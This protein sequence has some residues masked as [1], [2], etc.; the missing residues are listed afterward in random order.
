MPEIKK[1]FT[2]GKMNKDL[3]ERLVPNG[4][5]RDAMNIQVS[6]SEDS[7][8]GTVQ[9]ILGN[10]LV[11]TLS[12]LSPNSKCV[13]SISDEKDNALYWFVTNVPGWYVP[14]ATVIN[15]AF[16]SGST[17]GVQQSYKDIIL[18]FKNGFV[19]P[20]FVALRKDVAYTI[21][22]S[23]GIISWNSAAS[24][25]TLPPSLSVTDLEVGMVLYGDSST[26]GQSFAGM[27]ISGIDASTNTVTISGDI[28]WIDLSASSPAGYH[29]TKLF[30]SVLSGSKQATIL[31][32]KIGSIITGINIIDDILFWT[33][34]YSEPK[35]INILRSLVGTSLNGLEHTKLVVNGQI[36]GSIEESH[37]TV[38]K[39]GPSHAPTLTQL[40]S[41]KGVGANLSVNSLQPVILSGATVGTLL[42]DGDVLEFGVGSV[43]FEVG[44]TLLLT[45]SVGTTAS[46]D[47][48]RVVVT[49]VTPLSVS[50][51]KLT[52]EIITMPDAGGSYSGQILSVEYEEVGKNLFKLKFPRFA[53]RYK[54]EDSEY[55]PVGPFSNVAFIPGNFDYHQ[56]KPSILA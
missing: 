55:S 52:V 39:K 21:Y 30:F 11:N 25:I 15:P 38:I 8:V 12:Y 29:G 45:P 19:T 14:S 48:V 22:Q 40:T 31:G 5:Y 36:L 16:S 41:S 32:F 35:K 34:G 4:E 7:D 27:H 17:Q 46:G 26:L 44:D 43:D 2:G 9:N 10:K 3:D 33:D 47:E 13:G 28:T 42:V 56:Q 37:I 53:L 51:S 23:G 50:E 18:Q 20:V 6:T 49:V 24:T 54:Y 1:Q